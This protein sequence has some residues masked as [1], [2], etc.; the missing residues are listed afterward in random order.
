MNPDNPYLPIPA[1]IVDIIT[2]T[3]DKAI[4]TFKLEPAGGAFSFIC[5]QFAE[6]LVSGRG[7]APFG[8]ASSPL[9]PLLAFSVSRIGAVTSALHD[10]EPGGQVGL[11]GPLGNGF[12]L[13]L[14]RGRNLVLIGGGFGFTT[15]RALAAYVLHP[16]Q[17]SGFGA[18]SIFYGARSPG[19][20]LYRRELDS[21]KDRSDLVLHLA[22]DRP[23][24][25]WEGHV[26]FVP[27]VTAQVAPSSEN[28]VAIVCGPPIMI[29][30][31]LPV[32]RALGFPPDRVLLSLERKMKC[33]IGLCGRCNIGS[34]YVCRDGPVFSLAELSELPQED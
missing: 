9:E 13:D 12:P 1:R 34:R 8:M 29:K 18:L 5:G 11:R 19:L 27:A 2:E 16:E 21:W 17:R 20:L 6:I 7:E 10:L 4:K 23:A 30:K 22:I 28:A 15:L 31:T 32:L 33:G 25:G 14:L 26:G 24:P 3:E